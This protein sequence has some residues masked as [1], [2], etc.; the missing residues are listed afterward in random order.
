VVT[1]VHSII[2]IKSTAQL[3]KDL[4]QNIHGSPSCPECM[5]KTRTT[6]L[7]DVAPIMM[8]IECTGSDIRLSSNIDLNIINGLSSLQLRGVIYLG[9]YHFTSCIISTDGETWFHDGITTGQSCDWYENIN[10][11]SEQ[12]LST[13]KGKKSVL[14]ICA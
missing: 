11:Q 8:I 9:N 14:A 1:P 2:P 5:C 13:C 3:A 12:N 7:F 6:I 10:L 4:G